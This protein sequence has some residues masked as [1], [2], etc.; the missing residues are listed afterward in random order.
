[1]GCDAC[2][3]LYLDEACGPLDADEEVAG[4]FRVECAAVSGL[5]YSEYASD[6]RYHLVRGGVGR[7]VE[8]EDAVADVLGQ[9]ALQRGAAGGDGRVVTGAHNQRIVALEQQRPLGRGQRG[10][11]LLGLQVELRGE[12]RGSRGGGRVRGE[13]RGG[14]SGGDEG[15]G[16]CLLVLLLLLLLFGGDARH[17]GRG[18]E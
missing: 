6:P 11:R 12:G 3:E 16:G 9:R 7:L 4:D 5:L 1:M 8:V 10:G 13:G 15:S 14:G 18:Q 2:H 17:G